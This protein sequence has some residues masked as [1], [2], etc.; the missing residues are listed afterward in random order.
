M[1]IHFQLRMLLWVV[2]FYGKST[3]LNAVDLSAMPL[4]DMSKLNDPLELN[5]DKRDHRMRPD[6]VCHS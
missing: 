5:S 3:L 4:V 6:I 2:S 1:S